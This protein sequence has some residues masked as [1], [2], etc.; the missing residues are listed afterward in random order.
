[1]CAA[2]A[3]SAMLCE[4]AGCG[5]SSRIRGEEIKGDEVRGEMEFDV[6]LCQDELTERALQ[7]THLLP[8]GYIPVSTY[9]HNAPL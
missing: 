9:T 6:A 2:C 7:L 5:G 1:M 3:V 8:P 4:V